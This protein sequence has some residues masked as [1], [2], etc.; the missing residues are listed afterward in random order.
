M[1]R[2]RIGVLGCASIAWRKMLPALTANPDVTVVALASRDPEKAARFAAGFGGEPVTGYHQLLA[3][4]DLDAVYIPLPAALH[5]SWVE[6][7]LEAGLHVLAE[8]PVAT[9]AKDA[10]YLVALAAAR[11]LTLLENFMYR[12]HS[13]HAAVSE[14]VAEGTIGTVR[15]LTAEFAIPA[16]AP[17]NMRYEPEIGGGALLDIGVYPIRTALDFLGDEAEVAGATLNID[18]D[19]RVDVGGAALLAEP[20]GKTAQVTFG[21]RHGYRSRYELTGDKGRIAVLWAYTPPAGH[22]PI[23]RIEHQNSVE[24]RT[25]PPDD[26]FA[27]V[28]SRFAARILDGVPSDLVGPAIVAQAG[29]VDRIREQAMRLPDPG[30]E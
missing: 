2:L 7:A 14:L 10:E 25:L 4:E 9:K 19:L 26:Q 8:K 20:A 1:S 18:A 30:V 27:S 23:I 6:R 11:G 21:M 12:C 16:P 3:R 17:G 24:E 5:A 13:Q 22:A 15:S 28:V 29:L